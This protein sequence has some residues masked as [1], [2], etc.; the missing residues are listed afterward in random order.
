MQALQADSTELRDILKDYPDYKLTI[1]GHADERG[2]AEYNVALG[3]RRA[4]AAKISGQVGIPAPNLT[5]SAMAKKSRFARS[6]T[7][8]VG[9]GIAASTSWPRHRRRISSLG[10]VVRKR[11]ELSQRAPIIR[12]TSRKEGDR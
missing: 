3:D 11:C 2:S 10:T 8:P 12:N 6:T 7:K 9:S 5:S 1:E 4:T